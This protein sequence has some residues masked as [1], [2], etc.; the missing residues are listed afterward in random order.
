[1]GAALAGATAKTIN[2]LSRYGINLGIAF[3]IQ[4][5]ILGMFG[6]EKKLENPLIQT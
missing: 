2:N 3:Q 4:D 5:D 6:N 1:M